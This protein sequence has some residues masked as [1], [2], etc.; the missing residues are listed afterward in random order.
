MSEGKEAEMVQAAVVLADILGLNELMRQRPLKEIVEG[1]MASFADSIT[2]ALGTM[3]VGSDS[4]SEVTKELIKKM[5]LRSVPGDSWLLASDS[6]FGIFPFRESVEAAADDCIV[7]AANFLRR[8][9]SICSQSSIWV[10]GAVGYGECY[11]SDHDNGLILLGQ[12]IVEAYQ[13]ERSQEWIGGML[14]PSAALMLD[15]VARKYANSD[16]FKAV[17]IANQPLFIEYDIPLKSPLPAGCPRA[18]INLSIV[19][20]LRDHFTLPEKADEDGLREDAIDKW[21]NT[22]A[23]LRSIG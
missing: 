22:R 2:P 6:I 7:R 3:E 17:G 8:A 4:S 19:S 5:G 23:F 12:P 20:T 15:Q 11:Y 9:I 1:V 18:A 16:L 10:R 14:A 13:W 21:A